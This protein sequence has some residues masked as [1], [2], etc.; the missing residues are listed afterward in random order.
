MNK[1]LIFLMVVI[2]GSA[3]HLAKNY[4]RGVLLT[5]VFSL[6]SALLLW[7]LFKGLYPIRSEFGVLIFVWLILGSAIFG[8]AI[9]LG[10]LLNIAGINGWVSWKI[11]VSCCLF[12]GVL[13]ALSLFNVQYVERYVFDPT[14]SPGASDYIFAR[15]W[16][17]AFV[18]DLSMNRNYR[19]LPGDKIIF[20]PMFTNW[21]VSLY[22][23][24]VLSLSLKRYVLAR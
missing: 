15:G 10:L 21:L 17:S 22:F 1:F 9:F 20:T 3:A 2:V 5:G 13:T 11:V 19:W 8:I 23:L 6:I 14:A 4:S 16:P 24:L 18:G 12:A 7:S